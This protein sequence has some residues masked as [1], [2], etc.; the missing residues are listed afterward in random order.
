MTTYQD[1][2]TEA[3]RKIGVVAVDE[4]AS[5]DEIEASRRGLERMLRAWHNKQLA[6]WTVG[7][8][9]VPLTTAN[10][11]ALATRAQDVRSVRFKRS[12]I[13]T[14]MERMTR[15]EYDKLP[16][17]ATKGTPTTFYYDKQPD[18]GTLYIWPSLSLA[19][20]ETLEI[21][22]TDPFAAIDLTATSAIPV[23]W[24][25][26]VVYELGRRLA[27]DYEI[28][29][30]AQYF[31]NAREIMNDALASDRPDSVF[32]VGDEYATY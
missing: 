23:E 19:S 7:N 22:T 20:G 1:I 13:E 30:T 14:P 6:T 17:K 9:S 15:T 16:D 24:E 11:Y 18:T 31:A 29:L 32:F 5:A 25:D 8:L 28:T 21:T 12:G 26:A 4:Q 2:C 27:D 10:S 3:L